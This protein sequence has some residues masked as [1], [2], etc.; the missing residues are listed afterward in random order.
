MENSS[1]YTSNESTATVPF[2]EATPRNNT[3]PG[4]DATTPTFPPANIPQINNADIDSQIEIHHDKTHGA[5]LGKPE[6]GS[7]TTSRAASE[8]D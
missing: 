8:H 7:G 1:D 6:S 3:T 5:V 2:R 4:K